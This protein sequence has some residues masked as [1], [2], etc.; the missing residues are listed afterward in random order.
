MVEDYS[1]TARSSS[2]KQ[3]RGAVLLDG[4]DAQTG[5]SSNPL[6][7]QGDLGF[8]ELTD[9]E[10]VGDVAVGTSEV[11][12]VVAGTPTQTI[13]IQADVDNT[14]IIFIGKTGVLNDKTNDFV[15]LFAGDDAVI[16]YNDA[17]NAL[18]AISDTAAQK[19]NV[20]ALL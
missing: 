16:A 11:E 10:G 15:R 8:L 4:S 7:V 2:T 13:R 12:V 1:K 5:I 3:I 6:H 9:L 19:I 14:G 20:G 17:S 18:F